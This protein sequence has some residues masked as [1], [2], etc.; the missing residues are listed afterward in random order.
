MTIQRTVSF[1]LLVLTT[2]LALVA[3]APTSTN[4]RPS[5]AV[6]PLLQGLVLRSEG[7]PTL[8]Y[9][10][11]GAP[12]LAAYNRFIIDPVRVDYSDPSLNELDPADVVRMQRYFQDRMISELRD[13]GYE[14]ATRTQ[15]GTMRISLSLKG[16]KA[17]NAAANV[18][19]LVVPFAISVGEVTVEAVFREA[20]SDRVDAVVVDRSRGSSVFNPA[21]WST[22]SDVESAFDIWAEGVRDAVDEAHGR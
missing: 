18:S 22:W 11:P 6:A 20:E 21:P 3:C 5:V 4:T 12:T 14:I 13:G 16:L 10:R 19:V 8:I 2:A 15:P 7:E 17:P 1:A 9:V